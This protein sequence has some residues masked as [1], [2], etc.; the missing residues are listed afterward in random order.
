MSAGNGVA[1]FLSGRKKDGNH[2]VPP[3]GNKM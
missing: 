1:M 2:F 3:S